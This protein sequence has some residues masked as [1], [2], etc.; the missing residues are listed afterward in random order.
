MHLEGNTFCDDVF[1]FLVAVTIPNP[2]V[3]FSVYMTALKGKHLTLGHEQNVVY[4]GILTNE[5]NGYDDRC[6]Y[7]P[8]G[9]NLYVCC[10]FCNG[11]TVMDSYETQQD[12]SRFVI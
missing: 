3:G 11:I 8:C 12:N 2:G 6:V 5:G 10:R 1:V 4:D 7:V 9:G